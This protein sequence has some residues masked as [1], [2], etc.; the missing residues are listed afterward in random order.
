MQYEKIAISDI[1]AQGLLH[2]LTED[3][4]RGFL[5]GSVSV[6]DGEV[7]RFTDVTKYLKYLDDQEAIAYHNGIGYDH[8]AISIMTGVEIPRDKII[9]TLVLSRLA[10]P[11]LAEMDAARR[12]RHRDYPLPGYL[13]GS[14]SLKA[15]GYR[16]GEHKG[17]YKPAD[18]CT[19]EYEEEMGEYCDQDVIVT[20]RLLQIVLAKDIP[21][22]AVRL[23]HD[24]QWLMQKQE[25]NGFKFDVP[26]AQELYAELRD[27]KEN[28]TFDLQ[29]QYG[30]WYAKDGAS[31]SKYHVVPDRTVN[32]KE[33]LRADRT[34][35]AAF[36]KVKLVEFNPGSRQHVARVLKR[37][38]GW[39]PTHFTDTGLPEISDEILRDL[40]LPNTEKLADYY[41][42]IKILGMIGDG[43][44]AWLKL[45]S[46]D[47]FIHGSVNPL[48]TGTGRG[49]HSHPN[50]AQV[51]KGKK[52]SYGHR[53][54][55][56]FTTPMDWV[57]LGT[58]ASGLELRCLGHRLAEFDGG[59]YADLVVNGDVH[60][61]NVLALGLMPAGTERD[62]DNQD[63]DDA[64]NLA[65]TFIYAFLYGSGEENLGGLIGWSRVDRARW[66]ECP[67]ASKKVNR[68]K[69]NLRRQGR[70]ANKQ[71]IC[72]TLKG[73]ELKRNFLAANPAIKDFQKSCKDQHKS[74]KSV[75]GLD[76][77]TVP[78]RSAHSAPNF[79]LQGDGALICKLWG[80][81]L[82]RELTTTCGLKHG[83][84]GDFAFSAW[85]H[86][87][88]QIA[89]RNQEVAEQVGLVAKEAMA[90]VR[91][92]FKIV[93]ALD[94]DFDIGKTWAETH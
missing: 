79:Q 22:A 28:V 3:R 6:G 75:L 91:D 80:V 62:K 68:I 1:E 37:E 90:K 49:S 47:G 51:P 18:W 15:W 41:E 63:H 78:T 45:V 13:T 66:K 30:S 10:Y 81:L 42:V 21:A 24:I 59:A 17:D 83:W 70:T 89:C 5:C 19:A 39:E 86:D 92:I 69:A 87:E 94:A 77:R 67:K 14:H 58:D 88:Y 71:V 12:R 48:G 7:S 33:T 52:G 9:D 11:K 35:G 54:R 74:S 25:R 36:T 65:K 82:E 57:L 85:V 4:T 16:L 31:P 29:E 34:A 8:E 53:C 72:N 32:Y 61:A 56:L 20:R 50:V 76:G 43:K 64:R 26:A 44:N 23:E 73:W 60:W 84:D 93:P 55:E 38:H 46:K 40:D 2:H 27:V